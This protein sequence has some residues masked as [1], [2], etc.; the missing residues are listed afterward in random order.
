M[1]KT[2]SRKEIDKYLILAAFRQRE[3]EFSY[4]SYS[5]EMLQYELIRDGDLRSVEESRKMFRSDNVGTLSND[6]LRDKKYLFVANTT[7]ATRYAIEGGMHSNEA[8]LLSDFFIQKADQ[9]VSI[10][11]IFDLQSEMI[12]SF[13]EKV[14]ES[15]ENKDNLLDGIQRFIDEHLHERITLESIGTALS[16]SGAYLSSYFRKKTG[17]SLYRFIIKRKIA[18]SVQMLLHSDYSV[19]EIAYYLSFVSAS[20]YIET[21]RKNMGN[22]VGK[23]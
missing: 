6:P 14:R 18:V 21:F 20:H 22:G 7:L 17:M 1:T 13:T 15:K 5:G 2:I 4:H 9:A 8:Y 19:D 23:T 10:D 11:E 16:Y 12:R 3:Q